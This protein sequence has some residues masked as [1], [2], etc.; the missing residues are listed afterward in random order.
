M[1]E[2]TTAGSVDPIRPSQRQAGIV[3]GLIL[4]LVTFLPI[5]ATLSVA[6]AIPRLIAHF[7]GVPNVIVLIPMLMTIPAIC[8]AITSPFVGILTDRLGRRRVLIAAIVIYGVFG[9]APL[10]LDDLYAILATRVGV[11]VSEAM[12]FTV[13]KTLIGDYFS[14]ERRQRWVGYQNAIDAALGTA[15]WLVGGL[16][17]AVGWRAPFLLYTLAIPLLIAAWFLIW[18]PAPEDK[19]DANL[20][21][22]IPAFPWKRM[23]VVFAVTL[24]AGAMYFSYPTNIARALTELGVV[25][26]SRIGILTA[27]ASIG[28]PIGA[29]IFARA[30]FVPTHAMVGIGLAVIG[31]SYVAIGSSGDYY[32]ATG[33][34][35]VEQIGNG[36]LGAVLT[37]WCLNSLPF[38][39]RGRG[40]GIWGTFMVSGIFLS[41][42]FFAFIESLTGT[43]MSGFVIMGTIC[44]ASALVIP[45]IIRA[46]APKEILSAPAST[47]RAGAG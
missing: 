7:E 35:F 44:A 16:L 15:T 24:F 41:P 32:N 31:L 23:S 27:I 26:A 18:E 38:E 42:L 36:V 5:M 2:V 22:P 37:A 43:V 39:H 13:G 21:A 6:P 9:M 10:F 12:L 20:D 25:D 29:L 14:G 46:T 45:F 30:T 33:F 47:S 40:M 4:S 8:I 3:Q 1:A 28:T 34:G 17:A 11:G 19:N